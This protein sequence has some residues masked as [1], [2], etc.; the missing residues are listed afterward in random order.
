MLDIEGLDIGDDKEDC[1]G[2]YQD[3]MKSWAMSQKEAQIRN[4]WRRRI[5]GQ[6]ANPR[7]PAKW[8]LKRC[9]FSSFVHEFSVWY[10]AMD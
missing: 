7:V 8:P 10:H 9:F 2:L 4:K 6:L 3:H 1:R 5:K